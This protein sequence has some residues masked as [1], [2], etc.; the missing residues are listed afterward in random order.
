[1]TF[2]DLVPTPDTKWSLFITLLLSLKGS[3]NKRFSGFVLLS[4]PFIFKF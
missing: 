1:M 3:S 2:G 4:R